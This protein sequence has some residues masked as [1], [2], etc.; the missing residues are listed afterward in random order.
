MKTKDVLNHRGALPVL[1][2]LDAAIY[3][4]IICNPAHGLT[5][6]QFQ[7]V[8]EAHSEALKVFRCVDAVSGSALA[9]GRTVQVFQMPFTDEQ[10]EGM[11]KLIRRESLA[12]HDGH[13]R[14]YVQ[15]AGEE[16]K[17]G[18]WVHAR[19]LQP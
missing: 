17:Y 12:E 2:Q 8:A 7:A 19:N 4:G 15:F 6:E 1:R 14:W 11:A 18:R 9:A 5:P 13:E 3:S 10:P 16:Q